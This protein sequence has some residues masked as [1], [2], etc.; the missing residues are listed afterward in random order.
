MDADEAIYLLRLLGLTLEVNDGRLDVSP[1]DLIDDD[2]DW[3]LRT[4]KTEIIAE[5]NDGPRWAWLVRTPDGRSVETYHHPEATRADVLHKYPD[6]I[7]AEPLP[8]RMWPRS[9][10]S[11]TATLSRDERSRN[12]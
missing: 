7:S 8:E 2:V 10:S 1:S 5:L 3:L 4:N 9:A 12:E 6:A 11:T